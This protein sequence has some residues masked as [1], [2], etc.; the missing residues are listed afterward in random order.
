M[1]AN[2]D[3]ALQVGEGCRVH[4]VRGHLQEVVRLPLVVGHAP[5]QQ[6]PLADRDRFTEA[7]G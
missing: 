6:R 1:V 3:L 7:A 2:H 5:E 4:L